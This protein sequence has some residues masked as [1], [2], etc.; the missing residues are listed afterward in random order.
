M[1][2]ESF[3]LPTSEV[4]VTGKVAVKEVK[5]LSD[6]G[7]RGEE[8]GKE[9]KEAKEGQTEGSQSEFTFCSKKDKNELN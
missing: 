7:G 4:T 8:E 9:A 6:V 2:L 1:V 5:D 3:S